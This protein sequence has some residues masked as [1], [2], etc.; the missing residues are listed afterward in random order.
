MDLTSNEVI[1]FEFN[2][3]EKTF[4]RVTKNISDDGIVKHLIDSL[5]DERNKGNKEKK[6]DQ[7]NIVSEIEMILF[8]KGI[9]YP[10][11]EN[12][13]ETDKNNP[14]Y[15]KQEPKPFDLL[16]FSTSLKRKINN[17]HLQKYFI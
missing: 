1:F 14:T 16:A 12:G 13:S 8:K 4:Y 11:G 17:T 10:Y 2:N 5:L 9:I 6:L 15:K 3:G 7:K